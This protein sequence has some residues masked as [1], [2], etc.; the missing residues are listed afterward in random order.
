MRWL[1]SPSAGLLLIA[2]AI[3]MS[4]C[5]D[6][7]PRTDAPTLD[8]LAS[9]ADS[10]SARWYRAT[11]LDPVVTVRSVRIGN[12]DLVMG[13]PP[14]DVKYWGCWSSAERVVTLDYRAPSSAAF[15]IV[16]HELGH[17]LGAHH[18][19]DGSVM[20]EHLADDGRCL[21]KSDVDSACVSGSC[22]W[23][24]PECDRRSPRVV[25]TRT[26]PRSGP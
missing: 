26:R 9:I 6:R 23:R 13:P 24:R 4:A 14:A 10:A 3:G 12:C 2:F 20:A 19:T 17:V 21:S 7:P 15:L 11:G 22:A 5:G 8:P 1:T 18:P 25:S 16:T